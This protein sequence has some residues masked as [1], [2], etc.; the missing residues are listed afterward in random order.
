M[1][2]Y[3]NSNIKKVYLNGQGYT[4][5]SDHPCGFFFIVIFFATL[6]SV[7][8]TSAFSNEK[9]FLSF[10]AF[11]EDISSHMGASGSVLGII[12]FS[13]F[14]LLYV[15]GLLSFVSIGK[16]GRLYALVVSLILS[17]SL[18]LRPHNPSHEQWILNV[19]ILPPSVSNDFKTIW[20]WCYVLTKYFGTALAIC[21]FVSLMA[22][23]VR[24]FGLKRPS[25][26]VEGNKD[27]IDMFIDVTSNFWLRL[28][29]LKMR[30]VRFSAVNIVVLTFAILV[31]WIPWMLLLW[32]A[33][34]AADTVA[35]I[36]WVKSGKVWDPSSHE[37]LVGYSMSDHHPWLDTV[38]YGFFDSFGTNVLGSEAWGLWILAV[39]QTIGVAIA[40]SIITVYLGGVIGINW[41]YCAGCLLFVCCVPIFARTSMVIVKDATALPFFLVFMLL[42]VE[43]IRRVKLDIP[44]KLPIILGLIILFVLCSEMR[45]ISLEI[46]FATFI[47]IAILLRRRVVSLAVAI[48]PII[49]L[50]LISS[51]AFP[52]LHIAKGG[53]QETVGVFFQQVMY[54]AVTHNESLSENDRS[55][56]NAVNTCTIS[57]LSEIFTLHDVN[58]EIDS[59]D[60]LKDLCFDREATTKDVANL[61]VVWVKLGVRHPLSYLH[62]TPWLKD[63]FIMGAVYDEGWYVR[64]GWEDMG[65]NEVVLP[66]YHSD[67]N[68][69]QKSRPQEYGSVLY[70]FMSRMPAMSFFMSEAT[71]VLWIPLISVA[72]CL[73]KRKYGNLVLYTPWALTIA[74][75]ALLP[76]HQTRY[77]WTLAFG[78]I[79]IMAIPF[80]PEWGK[81][82]SLKQIEAE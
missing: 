45:K 22:Y 55:V 82:E 9:V 41:K 74:T 38:I 12:I 75:L 25:S 57:E 17:L 21:A 15:F 47:L 34:I 40:F 61:M 50:S 35:Q 77:T 2:K 71:Y 49:L 14:S 72:L 3:S 18:T 6:S 37:L 11:F 44:L 51:V 27:L 7:S 42:L 58:R 36:M 13:I 56:I 53:R 4:A 10:K 64:G 39:L 28:L 43:Y 52:A 59:D 67:S 60:A 66:Q 26:E 23:V 78:A 19:V 30:L 73:W 1:S 70:G 62:A 81:S 54:T 63:P 76:A 48:I 69:A 29:P 68:S 31:C 16:R 33:N 5:V 65:A 79:L 24:H 8:F 80:M 20:Y 46:F 32:P